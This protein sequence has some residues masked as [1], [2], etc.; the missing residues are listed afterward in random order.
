MPLHSFYPPHLGWGTNKGVKMMRV[1]TTVVMSGALVLS[2]IGGYGVARAQAGD[3]A[4]G[5]TAEK[6]NLRERAA[7]PQNGHHGAMGSADMRQSHDAQLRDPEMRRM[8]REHMDDPAMRR[9]HR[10]HMGESGMRSMGRNMTG[11]EG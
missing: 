11:S 8:H 2:G 4:A 5:R 6:I 7:G 10:E 9:M 3:A 1:A